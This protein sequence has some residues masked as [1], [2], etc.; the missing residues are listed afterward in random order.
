VAH[1]HISAD[2]QVFTC[3]AV[4]HPPCGL[5]LLTALGQQ[6]LKAKRDK[7]AAVKD[8]EGV[9]AE[10]SGSLTAVSLDKVGWVGLLAPMAASVLPCNVT[11]YDGLPALHWGGM[12]WDEKRRVVL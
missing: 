6:N 12:G 10:A 3:C 11:Q 9:G 2:A 8:G 1:V 4:R 7:A 5:L